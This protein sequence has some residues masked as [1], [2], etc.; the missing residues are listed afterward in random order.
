MCWG[1]II[2]VFAHLTYDGH[3]RVKVTKFATFNCHINNEPY[4]L[5]S[6]SLLI[7]LMWEEGEEGE[8]EKEEEGEEEEEGRR[9]RRGGGGGGEEERRRRR[10]GGGEEEEEEGR[11]RG[12]GVYPTFRLDKFSLL[13]IFR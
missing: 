12:G 9:R 1:L 5:Y 3:A 13:H 11:R 4:C 7:R 2:P 8:G 10:R 6:V